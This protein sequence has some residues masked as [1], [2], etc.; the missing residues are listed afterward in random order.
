MSD[1]ALDFLTAL[2]ER[3]MRLLTWGYVD[4]AWTADEIS[5]LADEFVLEHDDSGVISGTDLVT[6]LKSKA[7]LLV[8]DGGAGESLRTRMAE[9]VRLLARLRQLFP[10]HKDAK[11]NNAATLV[12]DFRIVT[13]PRSYPKRDTSID[14]AISEISVAAPVDATTKAAIRA[15]LSERGT[16]EFV[17]S[18][19]QIDATIDILRGLK[20]NTSDGTI[21][22][23]GTGS[24]KTLAFYLPAF[25][26]IASATE[27]KGTRVLAIYPRVELL[28]DQ[29]AEAFQEARR[30]DGVGNLGRPL[31]L[32]AL[33]AKTPHNAK[34]ADD[35]WERRAGNL[36]C[37]YMLCPKCDGSLIW[38]TADGN[39]T[40]R[41][42]QCSSTVG[43]ELMSL[44]RDSMLV[45]PPDVLFTTS[46]MLN[47]TL[48]NPRMRRLIGVGPGAMPVDLVLLDEVHTYE[49]TTG[50]QVAGVLRRWRHARRKPVHFVGLSATLREASRFF[51][52]LTDLQ[53]QNVTSVEPNI[54]DLE[55]EGQEYMLAVRAD[56]YSGAGVLSSTIQTAMLLE[57]VLDPLTGP[58]SDGAFGQR[59]FAFTDDLDVV[60]RLYFDLLDAEGLNSWGNPE[61][62]SLASLRSPTGGDLQARRAA[63]QIW[64]TLEQIGHRLDESNHTRIGRTTSQDANVDRLANA[65]VAT[66]SLE[67]GFN[68]PRVGA[69]LQHRA[70]HE[71]AAFLQ[72]KGRAGRSRKMR[73]WT[74]VMLSDFGRDR[75]TYHAYERL[76][77]PELPARA[78]PIANPAVVR[79][80][81]VF[82]VMDW[83][84]DRVPGQVHVWPALQRPAEDNRWQP[85]NVR[86]QNAL[87]D[88]LERL[89]TDKATRNDLALHLRR[90]LRCND[91]VIDEI[92]WQ[93]PRPLLTTVLPTAIRR[94]RSQWLHLTLG[95]GQDYVG[96]GPLPEFVVSSL[97]SDLALPEVT[98]VTAPEQNDGTERRVQMKAVQALTAF[99]P[100]R[101]SHRL[102]VAH[103]YD[104]HWIAPEDD[105]G[106]HERMDIRSVC[107]E[108]EELGMFGQGQADSTRVVRPL[109]LEL[110]KPPPGVSS[111]S[112]GR[113]L[114][115][116][117]FVPSA[118]SEQSV[119]PPETSQF[120][121]L[122]DTVTFFTHGGLAHVEVRR[123]ANESEFETR[124]DQGTRRGVIE[125][126]DESSDSNRVAVGLAI[127]VD[128]VAVD[129]RVTGHLISGRDVAPE[130]LRSLRVE[131]FREQ[132]LASGLI[133]LLGQ[134]NAERFAEAALRVVVAHAL[135]TDCDTEAAYQ[136]LRSD[137]QLGT[138]ILEASRGYSDHP[139]AT[140][141]GLTEL[142][143][144]MLD[145]PA[146]DVLDEASRSL[147]DPPDESWD[148]W[149]VKRLATTLGAVIHAALQ[150]LCP[151][152]DADE[153]V[154][155]VQG[156]PAEGT[157]RIW[158]SEQTIGGGGLIQESLRRVGDN[159]RIFFDLAA[160]AAQASV[161]EVVDD[162]LNRIARLAISD[163]AV[164]DA[165]SAVRGAR[166]YTER[167]LQ[168]AS[169]LAKLESA[170]AF[171]CHPVISAMSVRAL[172]PGS[173]ERTDRAIV[174]LV[175]DWD[176]IQE[177]LGL[178]IDL[179]T[180][181]ALRAND[182]QF[183]EETGLS[184]PTEEP[185]VWRIGQITGLLWQR[186]GTLRAQALRAPNRFT[187]L[188]RLDLL[189]LRAHL[190]PGNQPVEVEDIDLALQP[191]GPLSRDG[192]VDIHSRS[193]DAVALRRAI[194]KASCTPIEVGPLLHYPSAIG[195][196]RDS[197]GLRARLVLELVGE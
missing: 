124:T 176:R 178:D 102:T 65:I 55:Q 93:P 56:P 129:M 34:R 188:P 27:G 171:V 47:R 38:D 71:V 19:F 13:R 146:L 191:T 64:D 68:D 25:A 138:L 130:H 141:V 159:P 12:S 105:K 110:T 195:V 37:P 70:P 113:L 186:G 63:G 58:P 140:P 88:V 41:C 26:H 31:R 139:D 190:R 9:T 42:G 154:V 80:Q 183:D 3:E 165:M 111:S 90:A 57:R 4:N 103:R 10:K 73:P 197:Q 59:V 100:G 52:D 174:A 172:R 126:V 15:L 155:D 157:M 51:A 35:L 44:T 123:W 118:E 14:D 189:L 2:E 1:L 156:D 87:A 136:Q 22:G 85:Q 21:V 168:F 101:V 94:L 77:D 6:I 23:A 74:V 66:A 142:R 175:E 30:L 117:Q 67:V 46:E 133:H 86:D 128:A 20:S 11:W 158:L 144:A 76:F 134:F 153:L 184:A 152:Y 81:A 92:F 98:V 104:I 106:G 115:N 173:D 179:R 95:P 127:D 131:R 78:L 69:V 185:A 84:V 7:L 149:A 169:L 143:D 32:G 145:G 137:D 108:F 72:R 132:V 121:D 36:V 5:D 49:G 29:F 114:W 194:L 45:E 54:A 82:A 181:A 109:T 125:F 61:K 167:G 75:S 180:Y 43:P 62:P 147:W 60:N 39:T 89:L 162:E 161:D 28:R 164:A 182:T 18:R 166:A 116:T 17:L 112:H 148:N 97:F 33:Y 107:S 187:T 83:L 120:V 99:A 79:I 53:P 193:E 91:A 8:V 40:L 119:S 192:E 96:D 196:R 122:I 151:E 50:A 48:M 135:G 163:S 150:E 24:G 170:G 160:A 16:S 177:A